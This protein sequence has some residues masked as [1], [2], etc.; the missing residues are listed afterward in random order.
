MRNECNIIRD[1]LPLYAEG[2]TCVDTNE[3]IQEHLSCCE[4]CE[5]ELAR[6]RE[7]ERLADAQTFDGAGVIK[8]IRKKW[9]R[10]NILLGILLILLAV[11]I[12]TYLLVLC[13]R[14]FLVAAPVHSEDV[15]VRTRIEPYE[16]PHQ[17]AYLDQRFIIEFEHK[18]GKALQISLIDDY[19]IDE[20]DRMIRTGYTLEIRETVFDFFG[21]AKYQDTMS[22]GYVYTEETLPE[23]FDFTITVV[24]RDQTVTY[25]MAEEGLFAPQNFRP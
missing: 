4:E 5:Q 14:P 6:I 1:I 2:M 21:A 10:K 9:N 13:H 23:G 3:Y 8:A 20:K 12:G 18:E 7:P 19:T 24:Y 11:S 15:I 16:N 22:T 25:S 17:N